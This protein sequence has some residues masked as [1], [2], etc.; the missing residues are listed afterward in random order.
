MLHAAQS[1][2]QHEPGRQNSDDTHRHVYVEDPAPAPVVRDPPAQGR[3]DNRGKAEDRH[4]QPLPLTA[5]SWREDVPD[6]GQGN[7]HHRSSSQALD[8][9]IDDQLG[10]VLAGARQ[11][12]ADQE[13]DHT[14]Y[15]E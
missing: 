1:L 4:N 6:D 10:H 9:A 12:R 5:L 15:E 2:R 13:N 14:C 11:G 8:A 7:G 3:P